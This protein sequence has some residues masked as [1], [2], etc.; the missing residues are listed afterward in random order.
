[1]GEKGVHWKE[2]VLMWEGEGVNWKGKGVNVGEGVNKRERHSG[3]VGRT[4]D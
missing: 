4:L 2:R 3:P 1:M